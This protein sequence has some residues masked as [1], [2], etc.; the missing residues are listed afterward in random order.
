MNDRALDRVSTALRSQNGG[1]RFWLR[2]LVMLSGAT[3][4]AAIAAGEALPLAGRGL[5]LAFA[6]VEIVVRDETDP[7]GMIGAAASLGHARR[8]AA[9][10]G[11]LARYESQITTLTSPRA[12]WAGL[13]FSRPRIM[14]ILNITPDSFS[15]GGDYF[16]ATTAI[17]SGQAMLAAGADILDIGGES[18]RPG[19][20][21]IEPTEEIRRIEPVVRALAHV[22]ALI[23]IDTRNGATMQAALAAGA[24]IINDVSALTGDP[25][26]LAV[27]ARSEAPIVLM[28]MLGDPRTMQSDPVYA[29][30]PL[31]ILEYLE[32]RISACIAGGVSRERIVVD[33]GIGFGKRLRHNLQIMSRLSLLH[34]T[35]CPILLGAS[36][37]SFIASAVDRGTPAKERLPGSLAA[38]LAALD[39]GVQILRVHDVAETWQA[40]EVWRGI[41]LA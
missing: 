16:D 23:S 6:G 30:A 38:A 19:A 22:G 26:S 24:R 32:D 29:C 10:T 8:W 1:G 25:E 37:K 3:A 15:D 33:P 28:H 27:A 5:G 41:R 36:R 7:I 18:T 12:R 21:P 4:E 2:P 34:L 17:A 35:G 39:Q 13:D 40:A 31:D 9:V 20:Q 11:V 14:G